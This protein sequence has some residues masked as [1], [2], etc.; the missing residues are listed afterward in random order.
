MLNIG[1]I[2]RG[3]GALVAQPV[4]AAGI[5]LEPAQNELQRLAGGNVRQA[6]LAGIGARGG[7]VFEVNLEIIA[8]QHA[9]RH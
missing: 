5:R 9:H 2:R 1:E 3:A 7:A 4:V 8:R 6:R